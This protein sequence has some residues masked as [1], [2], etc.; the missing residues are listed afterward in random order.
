MGTYWYI[1]KVLPGKER[2]LNESFNEDI[3]EGKIKNI[4]RFVCPTEKEYVVVR[5]KKALREKVLYSG[6]LYFEAEERLNDDQLKW[7]SNI[8][9]IMG[10][11]GNKTPVMMREDDVKRIIKD[12]VL[13]DRIE[14]KKQKYLVGEEIIVIDGPFKTFEGIISEINDEIVD[15]EIK[16][17]GRVTKFSLSLSEIKKK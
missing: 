11:G 17:F 3:S 2:Q 4:I 16:I 1:V 9:N 15:I 5:N 12:E 8:P 7:I 6:Y 13:E 14:S 10:M